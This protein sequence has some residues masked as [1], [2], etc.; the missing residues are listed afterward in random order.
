MLAGEGADDFATRNGLPMVAQDYYWTELR[1]DQLTEAKGTVGAVAVDPA[2][3]LAA[4]TSTGG[5]TN[6]MTGRVGDSAVIGAGT[7]AN[8]VV[9]VSATGDGEV[10]LRGSAAGTIAAMIEFGGLDVVAAAHEV[11]MNRLTAL[12][13]TGG[14]IALDRHGTLATPHST[15]GL[16]HGYLT[17]DGKIVTKV[18][19]DDIV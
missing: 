11:V 6:K 9:A 12:G 10:F 18:F 17:A 14:V 1:W 8:D 7:F 2:G 19:A 15:P 13:G 5:M 4:A 16:Y 3:R